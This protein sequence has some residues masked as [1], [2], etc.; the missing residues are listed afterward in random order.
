[1]LDVTV[2]A[3]PADR[4]RYLMGVGTPA[5]LLGGDP[6][7]HR[8]VRL[9][10]ADPQRPQRHGLHR[11]GGAAVAQFGAGRAICA[12]W[13]K[14]APARLAA[15]AAGYLRHLFMAREMLG[16]ILLSIHNL[17]YYQRLLAEAR[18]AIEADD[19]CGVSRSGSWP[20]GGRRSTAAIAAPS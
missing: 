19:V 9:R 3:L 4:P 6:S 13:K 11:R 10:D 20:A 1:M 7:R 17:T 15:T 14:A 12:R 2:P 16:P 8:P 5:D 18:A